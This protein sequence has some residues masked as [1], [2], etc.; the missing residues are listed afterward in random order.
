MISTTIESDLLSTKLFFS[1]KQGKNSDYVA[2]LE[3]GDPKS[4]VETFEI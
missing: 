3:E 1:R 2:I 4:S